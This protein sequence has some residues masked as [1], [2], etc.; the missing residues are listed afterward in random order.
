MENKQFK[1]LI[2][3][4]FMCDNFIPNLADTQSDDWKE[5][6]FKMAKRHIIPTLENQTNKEFTLVFLVGN[7]IN[8][9]DVQRIY[10][11]SNI[12]N[13]A[14]CYLENFDAYIRN[15]DTDYLITSRLDY[16]DHVYKYC[17]EDIQCYFNSCDVE[18]KLYGLFEGVS[19]VDGKQDPHL[20][21]HYPWLG[22]DGFP[23]PMAT[24]MLKKESVK[25]YFDIYKL[26]YHVDIIK[27]FMAVQSVYC[28][29]H[30]DIHEVLY[31]HKGFNI[32]YIWIRHNHS[33]SKIAENVTHT[34]NIIVNIP[35][36]E[37]EYIYGYKI[38]N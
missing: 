25:K 16:D 38:N 4:R 23:A 27:N 13:I 10:G 26:G 21:Y 9:D 35:E 29:R 7:N 6:S 24:L 3:T 22:T 28:N 12:L 19:I 2:I 30:F 36:Y 18:V 8:A 31:N 33:A 1:H 34:T 5:M 20:M 37:L 17:V 14:V 11:L 32:D 15:F